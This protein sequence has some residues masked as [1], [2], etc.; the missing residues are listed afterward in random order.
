[1]NYLTTRRADLLK[2]QKADGVEAY[3]IGDP[4][5]LEYL[6]GLDVPGCLVVAPKQFAFVCDEEFSA[7]VGAIPDC[8]VVLR[9]TDQSYATAAGEVLKKLG[10]KSVGVDAATTTVA[11]FDSLAAA[12]LA[13]RA[14]RDRVSGL[15]AVKDAGEV[16][17]IREAA[18]IAERAFDMLRVL[19]REDDTEK[20]S[21]D[22]LD[23]YVRRAGARGSAFAPI[24]AVGERSALPNPR[25]GNRRI[26]DG[27]KLLVEWGVDVG[28]KCAL[29]RTIRSPFPVTPTRKTKTERAGEDFNDVAKAVV[30]AHRAALAAIRSEVP[31]VEVHA[32]AQQVI[33]EAGYA[34]SFLPRL[35]HG[36]G[37]RAV[38]APTLTATSAEV[39]RHGM[40]L[41]LSTGVA[42][43]GWGAVRVADTV[44][45]TKEGGTLLTTLPLDPTQLGD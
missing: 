6:S 27:S 44:L 2:S 20:E 4:T 45:V 12:G 37:L 1:M 23:S 30:T 15:R 5:N 8:E 7:Q 18:R 17:I 26:G 16:S 42:V 38:E 13:V 11:D 24:V 19:L 21:A 39:L 3:A 9:K 28:Y 25:P 40:V 43:P 41:V 34:A 14:I 35:G 29:T 33:A 36:I 22:A 32:A 31:V 10:V